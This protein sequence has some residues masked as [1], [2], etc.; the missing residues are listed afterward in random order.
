MRIDDALPRRVPV[1][2]GIV[3]AHVAWFVGYLVTAVVVRWGGGEAALDAVL[4]DTASRPDAYQ[5][6]TWVFYNAHG[7]P[8]ETVP[9][10]RGDTTAASTVTLVGGDGFTPLLYAVPA[11]VLV[12]AGA[13]VARYAGSSGPVE[14]TVAGLVLVP[15]YVALAWAASMASTITWSMGS[16]GTAAPHATAVLVLA[17]LVYPA[18]CAGGGGL[19]A[20]SVTDLVGSSG[21]PQVDATESETRR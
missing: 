18:V 1:L 10:A 17:G 16:D 21:E 2:A 13:A 5:V 3:A 8:V 20:G 14:G 4:A 7:A 19:L 12:G 9:A 11:V 6:V 15:A